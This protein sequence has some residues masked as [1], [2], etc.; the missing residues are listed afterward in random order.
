MDPERLIEVLK[1]SWGYS[2][3]LER[4]APYIIKRE[5]GPSAAPLRNMVKDMGILT[6]LAKELDVAL[7]TGKAAERIY[8]LANE[9][10]MA[11]QDIT[12]LYLL[13]EQEQV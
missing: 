13:L 8:A 6:Q 9:K 7:P 11:S 12:A 4:N 10:D 1:N 2:R 5:F 3:M